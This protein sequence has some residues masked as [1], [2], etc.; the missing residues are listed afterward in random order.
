MSYAAEM[1]EHLILQLSHRI[2]NNEHFS[3]SFDEYAAP[4]SK[5]YIC[6]NV[7][8]QDHEIYLLGMIAVQ[9]SLPS[10][11]AIKLINALNWI[12]MSHCW[13]SNRRRFHDEEVGENNGNRA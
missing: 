8:C 9:G 11:E 1:R 3:V 4:T 12:E 5:R 13:C 7:H 2:A 10:E 6:L